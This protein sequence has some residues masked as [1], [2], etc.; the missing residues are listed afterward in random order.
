MIIEP[1]RA[2]DPGQGCEC[3]VAGGPECAANIVI[4]AADDDVGGAAV[5]GKILAWLARL[6][7]TVNGPRHDQPPTT[8]WVFSCRRSAPAAPRLAASTACGTRCGASVNGRHRTTES[9]WHRP[10]L[11]AGQRRCQ[12]AMPFASAVFNCLDT[13]KARLRAGPWREEGPNWRSVPVGKRRKFSGKLG[14]I[15]RGALRA[16]DNLHDFN[17]LSGFFLRRNTA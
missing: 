16:L 3:L 6:V 10:A 11:F 5:R 9:T 12:G 2:V 13:T 14:N 1:W 8:A 4:P 17:R 7:R 15:G